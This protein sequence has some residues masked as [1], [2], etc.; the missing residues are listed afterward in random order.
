MRIAANCSHALHTEVEWLN[1]ESS[2]LKEWHDEASK[3]AIDMKTDVVLLRKLAQ[4]NNIVLA[5]IREVDS[6]ADDLEKEGE[7]NETKICFS[8]GP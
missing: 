8:S 6:R 7:Y 3:A 4:S 1:G 2:L 5:A